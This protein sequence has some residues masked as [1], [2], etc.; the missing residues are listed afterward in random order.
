MENEINNKTKPD[1]LQPLSDEKIE[2][3][4][5]SH[6]ARTLTH[7]TK[8]NILLVVVG[9]IL[10]GLIGFFLG[11][12]LIVQ[13]SLLLDKNTPT[14]TPSVRNTTFIPSPMLDPL[15]SATNSAKLIVKGTAQNSKTIKVYVNGKSVDSVPVTSTDSFTTSITLTE[16]ENLIKVKSIADDGKESKFS[17]TTLVTYD[18]KPP[19][20]IIDS[21]SDGESFNKDDNPI[22]VRGKT[23][24]NVRI[25]INGFQAI[26]NSKGEFSYSLPLRNDTKEILVI[27]VDE[28]GNT[29]EKKINL[30]YSE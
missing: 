3:R 30:S 10:L 7:K 21:P 28:A 15:T 25:T 14:P 26:T 8:K 17:E 24:T 23:D 18:N 12:Y 2:V 22:T 13:Y 16:G 27:A 11:P 20:L 1:L 29:T 19:E 4:Q 5:R 6:L 9:I